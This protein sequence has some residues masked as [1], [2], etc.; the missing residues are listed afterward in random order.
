MNIHFEETS[1][2][3]LIT[4]NEGRLRISG[5]SR[6]E[7]SF[8]VYGPVIEAVKQYSE[9]PEKVTE[10]EFNFEYLNSSSN[11]CLM[12]ILSLF[13]SVHERGNEV[14]ITW[15]YEKGDDL[16]YE[17]GEDIKAI[18]KVPVNLVEVV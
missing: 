4:F 15:K 12:S 14:L 2:S 13:E 17:L 10:A 3:P 7:D 18:S 6:P 5:R 11:R 1:S 8:Q 16:I 9:N